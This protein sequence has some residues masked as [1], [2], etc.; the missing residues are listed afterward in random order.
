MG[1]RKPLRLSGNSIRSVPP[2]PFAGQ[3]FPTDAKP[4]STDVFQ[5]DCGKN[6][7]SMAILTEA[8]NLSKQIFQSANSVGLQEMIF[9]KGLSTNR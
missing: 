4:L 5:I 7:S 6:H 9:R 2:Q 8:T 1:T 3:I